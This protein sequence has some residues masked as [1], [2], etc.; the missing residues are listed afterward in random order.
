[1]EITLYGKWRD[2][3]KGVRLFTGVQGPFPGL[4]SL[5]FLAPNSLTTG[6]GNQRIAEALPNPIGGD[7]HRLQLLIPTRVRKAR[8]KICAT[9]FNFCS[10]SEGGVAIYV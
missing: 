4:P 8:S 9:I 3:C 5:P 1:M 2:L 10:A 6:Y 7:R